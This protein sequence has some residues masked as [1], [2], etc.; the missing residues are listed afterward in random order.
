MAPYT[1][2]R[3]QIIHLE[4]DPALGTE[5]QGPH[6]GLVI[7]QQVFNR[8]GLAIVC[9]ISQGTAAS[10]R[11]YGTIVTLMGSGTSTQGA[12]HCHQVKSLDWRVRKARLKE[13]VPDFVMQ[14]VLARLEAILLG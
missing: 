2:E 6:F 5:M 12:I 7:S 8:L 10:A 3:G 14:E 4:F 13:N 9:P 1:P 11:T